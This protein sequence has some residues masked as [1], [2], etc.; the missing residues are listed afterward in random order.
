MTTSSGGRTAGL[1]L[2]AGAGR[3]YGMPKILVPGWLDQAVRALRDGGCDP[4]RV[5]TGA[6]RPAL[7]AGAVEIH[8]RDWHLGIG[9]SLRAG[10]RASGAGSDRVMIHLVDCPDIGSAVISRVLERGT[11]SLNRATFDGRPG[12]P[13]LIDSTQVRPLLASLT[14][15]VG[16]GPHLTRQGALGIECGDLATGQDVDRPP[17]R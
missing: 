6:A 3:R 13:V 2:A 10:L 5:V 17:T 11:A 12:H 1:L 15:A 7:P 8:C 16:A 9:A 14:N 4:V